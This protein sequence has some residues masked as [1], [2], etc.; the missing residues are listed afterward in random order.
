[1]RQERQDVF[2]LKHKR[3]FHGQSRFMW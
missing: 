3:L 2:Q 1:V